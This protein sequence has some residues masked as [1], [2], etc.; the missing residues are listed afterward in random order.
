MGM[1]GGKGGRGTYTAPARR[2]RRGGSCILVGEVCVGRRL[3]IPLLDELVGAGGEED[4]KG[5]GARSESGSFILSRRPYFGF[6]CRFLF[7]NQ[8]LS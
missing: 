7:L 1:G 4:E 5:R 3:I 2:R 8:T 6:S